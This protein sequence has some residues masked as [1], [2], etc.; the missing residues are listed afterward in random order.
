MYV[1]SV[2]EREKEWEGERE[3]EERRRERR[4]AREFECEDTCICHSTHW[5]FK[6]RLLLFTSPSILCVPRIKLKMSG[7][8]GK[9]F[10]HCTT[11]PTLILILKHFLCLYSS[12]PFHCCNK[13]NQKQL[14]EEKVR[15]SLQLSGH[16][17]SPREDRTGN[18]AQGSKAAVMGS[19]AH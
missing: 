19:A 12:D 18:W 5:E 10:P 17:P 7:L 8:G 1:C 3:R 13:H 11:L 4:R 14:G 15:F 2:C 9:T 6:G 16:T